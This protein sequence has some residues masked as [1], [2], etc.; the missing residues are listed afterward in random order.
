[1]RADLV[2]AV[3]RLSRRRVL[4]FMSS[5]HTDPDMAAEIFVLA[6]YDAVDGAVVALD[7]A[8]LA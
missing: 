8:V 2:A 5:N 7:G 1:M 6:P 3:E 4:A